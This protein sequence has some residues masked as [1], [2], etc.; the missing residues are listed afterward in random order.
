MSS[1]LWVGIKSESTWK[2]RV[3][4]SRILLLYSMS[5]W[6]L[7]E[8]MRIQPWVGGGGWLAPKGGPHRVVSQPGFRSGFHGQL[9]A[10]IMERLLNLSVHPLPHLWNGV[11]DRV[12]TSPGLFLRI[13]WVTVGNSPGAHSE[14][15]ISV[16][17][18]YHHWARRGMAGGFM[19][20]ANSSP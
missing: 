4:S 1:S 20:W 6:W 18:N 2:D 7:Q 12:P 13:E 19:S 10:V 14:P 15:G 3:V 8:D 16:G 11:S 17:C 5:L 9:A